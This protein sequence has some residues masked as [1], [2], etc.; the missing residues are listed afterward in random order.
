MKVCQAVNSMAAILRRGAY[1][2][3]KTCRCRCTYGGEQQLQCEKW[4]GS[5]HVRAIAAVFPTEVK[6]TLVGPFVLH[7]L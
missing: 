1:W 4:P 3:P 6:T 7:V 2:S 5:K